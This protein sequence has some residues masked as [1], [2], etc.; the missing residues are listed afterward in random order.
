[1]QFAIFAVLFLAVF[2]P[3]LMDLGYW[4]GDAE[5]LIY[6]A[7]S[8]VLAGLFTGLAKIHKVVGRILI[9]ILIYWIVDS[10]F[11]DKAL[12]PIL[13]GLG[14]CLLMH[15]R[16]E[17]SVRPMILVFGLV[18]VLSSMIAGTRP[19]LTQETVAA[20][21]AAPA[22]TTPAS[23]PIV[24]IV[25]DEFMSPTAAAR[26]GMLDAAL[27]QKVTDDYISRGFRVFGAARSVAGSTRVSVSNLLGLGD[28]TQP[29]D[30]NTEQSRRNGVEYN[31]V[32]ENRW[33]QR[34]KS[35]GYR[36][37][38]ISTS[39]IDLCS[40]GVDECYS[41]R[42]NGEGHSM[43]RFAGSL[44]QR[45]VFPLLVMDFHYYNKG[46][47][48]KVALY[49][50]FSKPLKNAGFKPIP[51]GFQ[52]RAGSALAVMDELQKRVMDLKPGQAYFAHVLMPH[53]PYIVNEDCSLKP[54]SEWTLQNYDKSDAS[55]AERY[56]GFAKQM[57]C[58]HK[59]ALEIVDTILASPSGKNAMIFI[60]GDHGSRIMK[61]AK[62]IKPDSD[63]PPEV[64]SD[65]LD[66]LF[67][68]RIPG[69]AEPGLDETPVVMQAQFRDLF[70]KATE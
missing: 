8:L 32:K 25:L 65:A 70:L 63:L 58:T 1:M 7:G 2:I 46:H 12:V 59:R 66:P 49:R 29:F 51:R 9:A 34:L 37:T 35:L 23:P 61:Q 68:V 41:Y 54:L 30:Y 64:I 17:N 40:K 53:N 26:I 69:V 27:A 3:N 48:G 55:D 18:F 39:Y 36:I 14:I 62:R 13:I 52:L 43:T 10:Y 47:I 38:T 24:H 31:M 22:A 33:V 11:L 42:A 4:P 56:Q 60:H 21:D 67:V 6:A 16:L 57:A 15:T 5:T 45:A 20:E 44:L 50:L 28:Q 19:L